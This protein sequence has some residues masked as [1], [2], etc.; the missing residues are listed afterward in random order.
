[1]IFIKCFIN[2]IL[3]SRPNRNSE[4][5]SYLFSLV[6]HS[7][8]LIK[9]LWSEPSFYKLK[10][11]VVNWICQLSNFWYWKL[12]NLER[13]GCN[14]NLS[15]LNCNDFL[16]YQSFLT[17]FIPTFHCNVLPCFGNVIL[18]FSS[19]TTVCPWLWSWE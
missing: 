16:L 1:M 15:I 10:W 11:S 19:N 9:D 14:K 4:R 5:P 6:K 8:I 17:A 3:L 7:K 2:S 12:A 18:V 13:I